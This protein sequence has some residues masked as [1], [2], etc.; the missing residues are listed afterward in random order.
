ME[1]VM[2][3][4][5]AVLTAF[6]LLLILC[7]TVS[8]AAG[9]EAQVSSY[10]NQEAQYQVG[11]TTT[12]EQ[13]YLQDSAKGVVPTTAANAQYTY[14]A[15]V[16]T[17]SLK[18]DMNAMGS[19]AAYGTGIT[20]AFFQSHTMDISGQGTFDNCPDKPVGARWTGTQSFQGQTDPAFCNGEVHGSGE[21]G[22][23]YTIS[24][25]HT[26]VKPVGSSDNTD[27]NT[28]QDGNSAPTNGR[29][30]TSLEMYAHSTNSPPTGVGVTGDFTQSHSL[31]LTP[32]PGV[33]G[34]G[35]TGTTTITTSQTTNTITSTN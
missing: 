24:C 8:Q 5:R 14:E 21:Q 29:I 25:V 9:D 2:E 31:Q 16:E 18:G 12:T 11:H 34:P 13:G 32:N 19:L 17:L 3:K 26:K 1:L 6:S 23:T 33:V 35:V 7:L 27:N 20:S 10:G 22:V 30:V 28:S 15:V 4:S